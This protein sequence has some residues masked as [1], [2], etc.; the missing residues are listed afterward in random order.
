MIDI[1]AA[2]WLKLRTARSTGYLTGAI[3]GCA[4]LVLLITWNA[5]I[6]FDRASAEGQARSYI[7]DMP[8]LT[9]WG[10]SLCCAILGMLTIT[11]EYRSGMI[12]TTFTVI[13]RRR[14][15]L[16]AKAIVVAGFCYCVGQVSVLF[17]YVGVRQIMGGRAFNGA[18]GPFG[19]ECRTLLANGL[20][21]LMFALLGLS[22]AAI[23]RSAVAA[24]VALLLLWYFIPIVVLN[25][26]RP[27]PDRIGSVLPAS[28][29]YELSGSGDLGA[30]TSDALLSPLG[31]L[32]VTVAYMI[33]PLAVAVTLVARR[34]T[35]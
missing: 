8:S 18:P 32:A 35:R 26:P 23:T 9:G 20:S 4:G 28:L 31:A 13:P 25:L 33:V 30:A 19:A 7:S 22:F 14:M 15:V 3:A 11:S 10:A 12:R 1:L 27:W 29:V 6:L 24:V 17:T 5:T 16:C 34:D 2:E 21:I